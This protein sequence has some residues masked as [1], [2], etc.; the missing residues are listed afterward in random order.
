[1]EALLLLRDWNYRTP[2][3]PLYLDS[4]STAGL[5]NFLSR[6]SET[7]GKLSLYRRAM[8]CDARAK[9]TRRA[10]AKGKFLVQDGQI[11]RRRQD[12]CSDTQLVWQSSLPYNKFWEE[13][14][15]C[16]PLFQISRPDLIVTGRITIYPLPCMISSSKHSG[17]VQFTFSINISKTFAESLQ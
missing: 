16:L 12:P 14:I 15:E 10:S 13:C 7:K 1:M 3:V 2:H 5:M 11:E 8:K 9:M 6:W 17:H 4:L